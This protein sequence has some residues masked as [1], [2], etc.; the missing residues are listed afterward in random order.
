MVGRKLRPSVAIAD[1][2]VQISEVPQ[3]AVGGW[4]GGIKGRRLWLGR[5]GIKGACSNVQ[6]FLERQCVGGGIM[7]WGRCLLQRVSGQGS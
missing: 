4:R 7:R 5:A 2:V 6:R 1:R 3:S